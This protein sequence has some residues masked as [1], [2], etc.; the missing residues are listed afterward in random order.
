[1]ELRV[2]EIVTIHLNLVTQHL[3]FMKIW[4]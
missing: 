2:A 1:M 3:R 4:I